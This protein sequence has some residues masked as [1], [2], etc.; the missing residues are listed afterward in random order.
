MTLKNFFKYVEIQTKT[1]SVT[2]LLIGTL[3]AIYRYNS[4]LLSNFLLMF[5]SLLCFDMATTAINNYIDYKKSN[6]IGTEHEA[7]ASNVS[8]IENGISQKTARIIIGVL[9]TLA[10]A[11][12]IKLTMNT[13]MIVLLVGMVS[14]IIGILYTF[15]PIPISRMPLG[16]IFS[17]FFMGFIIL[18]LAVYINAFDKNIA[19]IAFSGNIL[20]LN[21]NLLEVLVIFLLSVPSIACIANIM[22][23]N[24]ICDIEEDI[25]NNRFTLVYYLGRKNSLFIYKIL[26]YISFIDIIILVAAGVLPYI[27]LLSLLTFVI[28]NK[29]IKLFYESQVKSKTFVLAIKI[30]LTICGSQILLMGVSILLGMR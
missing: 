21:I 30:F 9:L 17:G 6:V 1:A 23:A 7:K 14:F 13:N 24:N 26:Y 22:L 8:V 12:G 16:E 11:F 5:A 29:R 3:F 10:I 27:M 18:F 2:P 20:T 4:F 25:I 15:G 28:V 19:S